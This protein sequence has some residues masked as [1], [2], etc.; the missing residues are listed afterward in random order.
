MVRL[1]KV[2]DV[3]YGVNLEV[4]NSEVVSS[5]GVPFV[6][7]QSVDN[8][9]VCHVKRMNN[10]E[11]NPPHTL[12]IA[13]SGSVLSTFYHDYEYYS[14]RDVYVASPKIQMTKEQMLYYCYVIEQNKYKYSYGRGANKTFMELLVPEL[15]EIPEYVQNQASIERFNQT[16]LCNKSMQIDVS[17]W[18]DFPLD[19]LFSIERGDRI[20]KD[21]DYF[22]QRDEICCHP[23]ITTTTSNNGVDGYYHTTNCDGDCLISAGE[24]NG[25]FTTYQARPC[26]VLDTA[27]IYKPKGFSLSVYCALFLATE[28]QKNMYRFSYGRK[29]KPDNMECL[30]VRLPVDQDGRPDWDWMERCIKSLPYSSC[31]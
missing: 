11:P 20:V 1:D 23:V 29:A 6:S 28:L 26:W 15:N 8:G 2:F 7:R 17:R 21:V 31:I 16:P 9:V 14:G 30:I 3:W 25:M 22:E 24:A 18:K 4:V 27:R 12:S 13:V 19:E 10:V 5:G